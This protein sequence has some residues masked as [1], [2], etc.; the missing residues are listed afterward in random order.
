MGYE[1]ASRERVFVSARA[2]LGKNHKQDSGKASHE[3]DDRLR[4]VEQLWAA[5]RLSAE[6]R[7]AREGS[8]RMDAAE[9]A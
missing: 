7:D 6:L 4:E 3:G 9:H 1:F 5:L 2:P 8:C